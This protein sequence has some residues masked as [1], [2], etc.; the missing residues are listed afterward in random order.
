MQTT[1]DMEK[2]H[3]QTM[4]RQEKHIRTAQNTKV[5]SQEIMGDINRFFQLCVRKMMMNPNRCVREP[6][7]PM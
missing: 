4:N 3:M 5:H 6:N 7:V 2:T 1:I